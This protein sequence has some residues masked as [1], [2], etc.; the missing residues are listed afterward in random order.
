MDAAKWVTWRMGSVHCAKITWHCYRGHIVCSTIDSL[1][2]KNR[3]SFDMSD[4]TIK[5]E[6]LYTEVAAIAESCNAVDRWLSDN[7]QVMDAVYP[8]TIEESA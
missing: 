7:R 2:E 6:G 3:V 5:A 8:P 1:G 4:G